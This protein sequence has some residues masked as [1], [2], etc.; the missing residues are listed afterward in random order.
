VASL[1]VSFL[2]I[3]AAVAP[4]EDRPSAAEEGRKIIIAMLVV[5]LIFISVI[6]LG[7]L[8]KWVSHRRKARRPPAY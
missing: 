3:L 6:V 7:Q 8:S 1:A 5:A 4:E 2:S